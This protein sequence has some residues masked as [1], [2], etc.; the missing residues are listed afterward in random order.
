MTGLAP[1][2]NWAMLTLDALTILAG[3]VVIYFAAHWAFQ[4]LLKARRRK[5]WLGHWRDRDPIT[6][7]H[8]WRLEQLLD[9]HRVAENRLAAT[10]GCDLPYPITSQV[11]GAYDPDSDGAW[12]T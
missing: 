2:V 10:L 6:R 3:M 1:T 12:P 8:Q 11:G 7:R 5:K 9:Q 4:P